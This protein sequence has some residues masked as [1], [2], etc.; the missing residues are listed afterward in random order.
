V[1]VYD[2]EAKTGVLCLLVNLVLSLVRGYLRANYYRYNSNTLNFNQRIENAQPEIRRLVGMVVETGLDFKFGDV[3]KIVTY[4]YSASTASIPQVMRCT[5]SGILG[6]EV[7]DILGNNDDFR[8]RKLALDP[9]IRTWRTFAEVTDVVFCK[10]FGDIV[11]TNSYQGR[12]CSSY[13]PSGCNILVC[14]FPQLKK[15]FD[16]IENNCYKQRGRRD[17]EW[18][19]IGTPFE[20]HITKSGGSCD[21]LQ[22]WSQRLQSVKTGLLTNRSWRKLESGKHIPLDGDGA[23]CFGRLIDRE[24]DRQ[25]HEIKQ[26]REDRGPVDGTLTTGS[27]HND[28]RTD[29]IIVMSESMQIDIQDTDI[30]PRAMNRFSIF[31]DL[32]SDYGIRCDTQ[33][34]ERGM[35]RL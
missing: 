19:L 11:K 30:D 8:A 21:G 1:I 25:R 12:E 14:P 13:P 24:N 33:P 35:Q 3:F 26:R 22:C 23:V 15:H 31:Q 34:G 17:L 27:S 29:A 5:R 18:M 6:F 32:P 10:M 7:A 4:R 2:D 28:D 20:C 9:S 16:L